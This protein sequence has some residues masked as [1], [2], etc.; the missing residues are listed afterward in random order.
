[1]PQEHSE[2]APEQRIAL[3]KSDNQS[4]SLSVCLYVHPS[5]LLAWNGWGLDLAGWGWM[6]L[7]VR[8]YLYYST[9]LQHDFITAWQHNFIIITAV[10][11]C[12]PEN[13]A[14]KKLSILYY[15]YIWP[16]HAHSLANDWSNN[17][18]MCAHPFFYICSCNWDQM[19]P[20]ASAGAHRDQ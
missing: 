8:V 15:I 7:V 13:S 6:V 14:I 9:L 10:S 1:M 19:G 2:S 17:E 20:T 11:L 18:Q 5:V 3:Y 4:V 12:T 16:V